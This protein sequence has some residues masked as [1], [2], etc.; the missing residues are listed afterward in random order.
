MVG[1]IGVALGI[2]YDRSGVFTFLVPGVIG[3]LIL[4][5]SWVSQMQLKMWLIILTNKVISPPES[6]NS[7]INWR[8]RLPLQI[9]HCSSDH[10]CYPGLKYTCCFFFP[11][12]AVL[13][14]GLF[15]FMILEEESNYQFVHSAWHISMAVAILFLLP[16]SPPTDDLLQAE[17]DKYTI[18]NSRTSFPPA[19]SS[20]KHISADDT[21]PPG[22]LINVTSSAATILPPD[23]VVDVSRAPS[24]PSLH[25][26]P[27]ISGAMA[28]LPRSN[29]AARG[30]PQHQHVHSYGTM[31]RQQQQLAMTEEVRPLIAQRPPDPG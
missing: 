2:E 8:C 31:K 28:T 18:L 30:R 4:F 10:S 15:C 26:G 20:F 24:M 3:I 11:G 16:Q 19:E 29:M 5:A 9:S 17:T 12:L 13:A 14:G 25:N 1:A 6:L 23:Q 21:L 27:G 7:N 22:D